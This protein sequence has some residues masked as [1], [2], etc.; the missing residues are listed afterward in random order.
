MKPT[1]GIDPYIRIQSSETNHLAGQTIL[2]LHLLLLLIPTSALQHPP[3]APFYSP[4]PATENNPSHLFKRDDNCPV[5]YNSCTTLSPSDGAACCS[6]GS[7]CTLDAASNIACC[8]I[9]ALCTGVLPLASSIPTVTT[10]DAV[11]TVSNSYFPFP[12]VATTYSN[13]LACATASSVCAVNYAACTA[14]LTGGYGV[15]IVAPGG[16][17]TVAPE[18]TDVGAA[19]AASVCSSLS[20]EA[21]VGVQGGCAT[22]GAGSFIVAT[23]TSGNAAARVTGMMG[24]GMGMGMGVVAGVGLGVV[25]GMV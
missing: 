22:W 14:D 11:S 24:M 16:G 23:Q 25:R 12:Y 20:S 19:Q 21:C 4:L 3:I 8:P 2:S 10:T 18:A 7:T 13:S 15:T 17:V 9:G 1:N 5:N 6:Q